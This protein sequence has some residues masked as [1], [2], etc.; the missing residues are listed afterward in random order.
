MIQFLML[1]RLNNVGLS[2]AGRV[3]GSDVWMAP[4]LLA[5]CCLLNLR[6]LSPDVDPLFDFRPPNREVG[7]VVVDSGMLLLPISVYS[8]FLSGL[9]G[10]FGS[11]SYL[12]P[13]D[14]LNRLLRDDVS[15]C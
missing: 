2:T 11:L 12:V 9:S 15:F 10:E 13:L 8:C 6:F 4:M 3:T 1:T 7:R 14:S 5:F